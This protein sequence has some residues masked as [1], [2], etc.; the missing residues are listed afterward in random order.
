MLLTFA[1]A[2]VSMFYRRPDAFYA[3]QFWG[4][5]GSVFYADA[6]HEGFSSLFNTCVG[7]FHLYPRLIACIAAS[8]SIPLQYVPFLFCYSWLFML[9]CVLAYIWKRLDFTPVQKFFIAITVVMIPLQSEVFMNLTNVQW[10][11]ALFPIIILTGKKEKTR[12]GLILDGV[13]MILAGFTGPNFTI[14]LPALLIVCV[15]KRKEILRGNTLLLLS[16]W[17]LCGI[18][19][20]ISLTGYGNVSRVA[21]EFSPLNKDFVKIVFVQY[22]FLFIGKLASLVPFILQLIA[23]IGMTGAALWVTKKICK[24]TDYTFEL[25]ILLAGLIYLAG[26]LISYR[27]NPAILSPYYGA[28]R[29]FYIPAVTFVWLLIRLLEGNKYGI[30]IATAIMILFATETVLFVGPMTLKQYNLKEYN[31]QLRTADTLSIPI[32]P[33]P[34]TIEID[35]RKGRP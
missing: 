7:Y 28:P 35:N 15:I 19:G 25:L 1:I 27:N 31:S 26:S 30:R 11:M 8:L 10:I 14:L 33:E 17:L 16:I 22:A 20:F 13:F 4:E 34:W 12:G 21:G 3:S 32:N 2:V 29:N 23:V 5:E 6:Y 18:V 24:K 9:F